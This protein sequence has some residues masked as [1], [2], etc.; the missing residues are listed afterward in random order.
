MLNDA[1]PL[2]IYA[3]HSLAHRIRIRLRLVVDD[4]VA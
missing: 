1:E 2:P 4:G 3:H